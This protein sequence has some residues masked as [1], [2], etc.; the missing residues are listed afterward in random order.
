MSD[1]IQVVLALVTVLLFIGLEFF[2][3]SRFFLTM[4]TMVLVPILIVIVA[5]VCA[6]PFAWGMS[7]AAWGRTH[8]VSFIDVIFRAAA[9]PAVL[10][11]TVYCLHGRG[12]RRD[13]LWILAMCVS[14]A[15]LG[16]IWEAR[17]PSAPRAK[18]RGYEDD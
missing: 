11:G 5:L 10:M 7:C 14:G 8:Q 6:L 12:D 4:G 9:W 16:A 18:R 15:I 1:R 3:H 13:D 17:Y 2:P